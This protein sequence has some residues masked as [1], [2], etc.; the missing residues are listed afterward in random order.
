[1]MGAVAML[2]IVS[3]ANFHAL[4]IKEG[5]TV[6]ALRW[7]PK[8]GETHV[9]RVNV[10]FDYGGDGVQFNSDLK[11]KVMEVNDD[12]GYSVQTST[13]NA[14]LNSGNETRDLPLQTPVTQYY[15]KLGLPT[16]QSLLTRDPD[17]F[18]DLLDHLTEFQAPLHGVKVRDSWVNRPT[19]PKTSL[20]GQ[21]RLTYTLVDVYKDGERHLAKI[22]YQASVETDPEAASGTLILDRSNFYL[23]GV[24]ATIPHFRPEGAREDAAV[25]ITLREKSS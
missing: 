2:A 12:G 17:P 21:P 19:G 14:S 6:F 1:M 5:D 8:P 23:T 11:V 3:T 22:R 15:S 16:G 25:T 13:S 24:D 20:F 10:K 4:Q 18:A 7:K 9:Y